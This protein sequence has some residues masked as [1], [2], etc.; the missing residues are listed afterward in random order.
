MQTPLNSSEEILFQNDTK[1]AL[2]T[3]VISAILGAVMV[4]TIFGNILVLFSFHAQPSLRKVKYFPIFS[5]ALADLLCAVTAMP[6][7]ITKKNASSE[8]I[9]ARLVCDLYRFSYF[10]TEYASI[11]SLMVISIERFLNIKF[12]LKYMNCMRA[13]VMICVLVA[14]WVEALI[15]ATMPFYWR[16]E[17][18]KECT[19][20]PTS[21]WSIVA[22]SVN[23]FLPFLIMF[24]SHC[25]IY[26][27]TLCEFCQDH[28][29]AHSAT[30]DHRRRKTVVRAEKWKIEKRA[31]IS[32]SVVVGVFIIC[33]GPST[34]YYFTAN[35]SP[36]SFA[37]QSFKRYKSIV[38][39]TMKILTFCNS[40]M[41][42]VIYFWLNIDFRK[43]FIRILKRER[44]MRTRAGTGN[45]VTMT[46]FGSLHQNNV[47]H[48]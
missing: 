24:S 11:M 15:V 43:A 48:V 21:T 25:Y 36:E 22:I 10:F 1:V 18:D 26:C 30:P 17:K 28:S 5:L 46:L 41:N 33:W 23:V 37:D 34:I 27:K 6:L 4:F 13:R 12:P 19:N 20:S 16:N 14:C 38:G 2:N 7:Y 44:Q 40:F 8:N 39:A 31:T 32:F 3:D 47:N 35:V 9:D 29:A 42:P 45:S